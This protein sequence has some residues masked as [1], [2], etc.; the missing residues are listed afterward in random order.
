M[1][2]AYRLL[3]GGESVDAASGETFDSIDPSTGEVFAS[4]AKGGADDAHRAVAAA[5]AAF[6]QGPWPG[7]KGRERA[8]YLMKVA[9]LVKQNAG[10]LAELEARD[11]GHTIRPA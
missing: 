6:D 4:V 7:M 11:A 8:G 3:I 5:R 2:D 10:R 1:T 9:D